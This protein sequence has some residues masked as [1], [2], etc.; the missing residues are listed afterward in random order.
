LEEEMARAWQW[1]GRQKRFWTAAFWF[2]G[3]L[4]FMMELSAGLDYVE[5]LFTELAPNFLGILP[6]WALAG[7]RVAEHAFWNFGQLEAAFRV[8]PLLTLPFALLGLAMSMKGS[9][10]FRGQQD[11]G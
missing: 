4:L 8:L 7:W 2:T 1:N 5:S 9:L 6:A 10:G 11:N 3:I